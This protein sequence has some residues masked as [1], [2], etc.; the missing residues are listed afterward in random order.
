MNNCKKGILLSFSLWLSFNGYAQKKVWVTDANKILNF[1]FQYTHVFPSGDFANRFENFNGIG[2]GVMLKT[3]HNVLLGFDG[4]YYFGSRLKPNNILSNLTNANGTISNGSGYPA[5]LSMG[6]RGFSVLGKGG[7]VF[8]LSHKNRNSGIMILL[9]GGL[10]MHKI[11]LSTTRNDIASL[12][13]DKKAGYDRYSS[14]WAAN[15]FI[16]Y[17]HQ[18]K[19]KAINF[20]VGV[21]LMQAFTYNRRKFNYDEMA[22]DLGLHR[23]YYLGLRFGWIIPR[24]I[25]TKNNDDEFIFN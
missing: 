8:P 1:C 12:T 21:D 15:Q 2:A 6:M 11:N 19:N 23:D 9:G 22:Y 10:V 16:G 20:Y 13:E 7:Y 17:I 25:N 4:N 5:T 24:Y 14:G 3:K 18:S